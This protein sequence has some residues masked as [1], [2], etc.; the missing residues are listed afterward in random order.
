M[1][2]LKKEINQEEN[3]VTK[4]IARQIIIEALF[5]VWCEG[6]YGFGKRNEV[7]DV[8]KTIDEIRFYF[9][10]SIADYNYIETKVMEAI[11]NQEK[12]AFVNG[13]YLCL[14]LLNGN[15]MKC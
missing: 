5:D 14:E 2:E 3:T 4:D 11:C 13:F 7:A 8:Q 12:Y 10:G 6:I 1:P 9:K 15:I